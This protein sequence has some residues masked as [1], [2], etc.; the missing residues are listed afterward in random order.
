[1]H[2]SACFPAQRRIIVRSVSLRL[3]LMAAALASSPVPSPGCSEC[4]C[5]LSSDWAAQGYASMPGGQASIRYE[6]YEQSDLRSGTHALD[7]AAQPRP[8]SEEIQQ[9]TLNRNVWLGFD[10]VFNRTW[11]L[12]AQ[13]PYYNR[14]H[15]TFAPGDTQLS[16][17]HARGMGDLQLVGRYQKNALTHS[18]GVQLGLKLPTGRFGQ[19][20]A[21]GP[22]AGEP[23]DRGLQLGSGTADL[24]AGGS[25]FVRPA[26]T[27]GA[28]AQVLVDQ[29]LNSRAGF[30]PAPSLSLNAG[31]R[32]LTTGFLTPQVQLN[33]RWDGRESGP[34]SDRDNSGDTLAYLSPGITADVGLRWHAF[35]FLQVPV[36]QRVNGLQLTPRWLVSTGIRGQF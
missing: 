30:R 8:N 17:S 12:S 2:A 32:L 5:S 31:V 13:V 16:T 35:A 24:L 28:F 14:F 22:Q 34:N 21:S 3:G 20:F 18:I 29:P 9:S 10:Y 4:G 6:Y 27:V 23:L 25:Y 36:Y 15:S 26:P 11:G 7:R 33:V 1:M 19:D